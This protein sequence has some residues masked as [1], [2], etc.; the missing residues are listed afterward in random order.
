M[1]LNGNLL[2]RIAR[3]NGGRDPERLAL[4]YKAMQYARIFPRL[5]PECVAH[6][7]SHSNEW[8]RKP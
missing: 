7:H 6:L 1:N 4:K 3:F 2:P 5:L 8:E